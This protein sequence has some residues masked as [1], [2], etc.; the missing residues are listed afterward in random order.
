MNTP[1]RPRNIRPGDK[2]ACVDAPRNS[3]GMRR[4]LTAPPRMGWAYLVEDVADYSDID[5]LDIPGFEDLPKKMLRL[6]GEE[7]RYWID[8]ARFV[9]L[10]R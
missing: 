1:I 4:Y 3:N 9:R 8:C 2:V 6:R 5:P 10:G 7:S